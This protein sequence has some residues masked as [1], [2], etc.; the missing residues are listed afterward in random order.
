MKRKI[1]LMKLKL[2]LMCK[3]LIDVILKS[4]RA[5]AMSDYRT[6][7]L[8]NLKM[9]EQTFPKLDNLEKMITHLQAGRGLRKTA[10]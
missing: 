3:A 9:L 10:R 4:D 1:F 7:E 5:M 6:V 8:H 2:N